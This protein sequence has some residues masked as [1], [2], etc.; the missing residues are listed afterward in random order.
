MTEKGIVKQDNHK[1]SVMDKIKQARSQ[2][3]SHKKELKEL[4]MNPEFELLKIKR[5]EIQS[6]PSII[7]KEQMEQAIDDN[8]YKIDQNLKR[9][10][11]DL[12]R[13]IK[14]LKK[15]TQSNK[16]IVEFSMRENTSKIDKIDVTI[17]QLQGKLSQRCEQIKEQKE[18][19]KQVVAL[20][21]KDEKLQDLLTKLNE[22]EE[23]QI[24]MEE[25]NEE[26]QSNIE[27]AQ[28]LLKELYGIS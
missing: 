7:R 4:K 28:D 21:G 18:F 1:E 15:W 20:Q 16:S 5:Q 27:A 3:E 23:D 25:G 19:I 9:R 6:I 11:R 12:R 26:D 2:L 8:M 14:T 17:R 13:K 10:I 22:Q 24:I